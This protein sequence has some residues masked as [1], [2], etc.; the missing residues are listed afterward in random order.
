MPTKRL[1]ALYAHPDDETFSPGGTMALYAAQG[2]H[3]ELVCATRGEAGEIADPSLATPATLPQV[4]EYELRC[5][6][7]MLGIREVHFLGYR[8]SGMEG[9]PDNDNPDAFINAPAEAVVAQLVAVIRRLRPHILLTFEPWGGYGHPDH[10]AIHRHA[11]AA[12]DKAGD[13]SYRPDLGQPWHAPRVFYPLLPAFMFAHMRERMVAHG[14]DT[15]FFDSDMFAERRA[16]G[17][18][19]DQIH[20]IMDVSATVERKR[21]AFHCHRTQF[22][23][24][25]L[26]RQLPEEAMEQLFSREYFALARPEPDP[27]TQLTDIFEGLALQD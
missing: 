6:A 23:E 1:L 16:K 13:I 3:I 10:R 21:A 19:D 18:P 17:W 8:D 26:F 14:L 25:N 20:C 4:R 12:H 15:S 11:L 22:G 2:A 7:Q 24:D 5:A 27:H 9:T